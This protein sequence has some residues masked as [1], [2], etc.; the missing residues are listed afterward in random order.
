MSP[1]ADLP[2]RPDPGTGLPVPPPAPGPRRRAPTRRMPSRPQPSPAGR[3]P[4]LAGRSGSRRDAAVVLVGGLVVLLV[5][6][7][8]CFGLERPDSV[9]P[10]L[11]GVAAFVVLVLVWWAHSIAANHVAVGADWVQSGR[12]WLDLYDLGEVRGSAGAYGLGMLRF[13]D[14]AGRRLDCYVYELR[15]DP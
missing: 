1:T 8:L 10:A 3:G 12:G 7:D 14:A 2:P 15:A 13:R 6:E 11:R 9:P 4:V 5:L